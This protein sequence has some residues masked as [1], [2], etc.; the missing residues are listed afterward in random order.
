MPGVVDADITR[1]TVPHRMVKHIEKKRLKKLR[2]EQEPFWHGK[3]VLISC[4]RKQF[5]H[6]IGQTYSNISIEDLA[7]GSWKGRKSKSDYFTIN[8]FKPVR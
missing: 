8:A 1:I 5:N 6:H 3:P 2:S 7:S 4:K